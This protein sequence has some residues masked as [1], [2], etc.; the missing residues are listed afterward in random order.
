MAIFNRLRNKIGFFG[1][2]RY[3]FQFFMKKFQAAFGR[4]PDKR[5]IVGYYSFINLD[6]YAS[7]NTREKQSGKSRLN[8][9]IPDFGL[10]SGG[11]LNIFRL[12]LNLEELGYE[13]NVIIIPPCHF[14]S[15]DEARKCIQENFFP[16]K[17]KVYTQ[18]DLMPAADVT[19][20]TSWPTA[21]YVE[22]FI[23]SG[24]KMY[25][26]QDFEPYF[27]SH[28]SEYAFAEATYMFG[29]IGV[30]AGDWLAKKLTESYGMITHSYGFSYDSDLYYPRKRNVLQKRYVFFYARPVTERRGFELG[31]L[32]LRELCR[33]RSGLCVVLAGWDVADYQI[34]FPHTNYG[35]LPLE[36]LPDLYS[37]CDLALV[38]SFTNISLL[39]LEL[40]ATGCP[41]ISNKGENVEWLLN[42]DNAVLCNPDVQS[43][44]EG[45]LRLLDDEDEHKRIRDAG[46]Q[47]VK[48]SSWS[49]EAEKVAKYVHQ[50]VNADG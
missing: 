39:P 10:G 45:M 20:A 13:C 9:V 15:D 40:M 29:F 16:I 50:L 43:L 46:L 37:Q 12:I 34:D 3:S 38:L 31:I 30:T 33:L 14:T 36:D 11:H 49:S 1:A 2:V 27:Y 21:Y 28:G 41:V 17:A 42:R 7:K 18:Y 26:V 24:L 44:V 5:D 35:T 8:W 22:K 32:A 23:D 47:F 6:E 4:V 25:F 48:N 19:F